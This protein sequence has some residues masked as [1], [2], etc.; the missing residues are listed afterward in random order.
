MLRCWDKD[1]DARPEMSDVV[2][3]LQKFIVSERVETEKDYASVYGTFLYVK[4]AG[5]SLHESGLSGLSQGRVLPDP[6]RPVPRT[7][8]RPAKTRSSFHEIREKFEHCNIG[9]TEDN[10]YDVVE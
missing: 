4:D 8:T 5:S 9:N 2:Q 7:F 3:F 10:P 6:P 1:P